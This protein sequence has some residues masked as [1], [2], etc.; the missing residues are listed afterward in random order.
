MFLGH[1]LR[2]AGSDPLQFEHTGNTYD[3]ASGNQ[4]TFTNVDIG[5][6][7]ADRM[8]V[9]AVSLRGGLTVISNIKINAVNGTLTT[10]QASLSNVGISF[11]KV[12]TGTTC[13]IQVNLSNSNP[14]GCSLSVYVFRTSAS[15]ALDSVTGV[16]STS[17][18]LANIE[19]SEGGVVIVAGNKTTA[20]LMTGSWNGTDSNVED[21]SAIDETAARYFSHVLT[22]EASTTRD[23][24]FTDMETGCAVSFD[25]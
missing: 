25:P 21:Y 14:T 15:T 2:R 8:V 3:P 1:K 6:A 10:Q 11:D 24:T 16:G 23:F 5:S 9:A 20:T 7:H 18:I 12:S 22:T 17:Q 4:Y 13:T 19:C